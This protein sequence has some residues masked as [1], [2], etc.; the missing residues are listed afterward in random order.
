MRLM[1]AR[2]W[3]RNNEVDALQCERLSVCGEVVV[4]RF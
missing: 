4:L 1:T 2:G 3:Q